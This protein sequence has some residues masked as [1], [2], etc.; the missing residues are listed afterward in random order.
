LGGSITWESEDI[1]TSQ[2]ALLPLPAIIFSSFGD[3]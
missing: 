3:V 1:S 2:P